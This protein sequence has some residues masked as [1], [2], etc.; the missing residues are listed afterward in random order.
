[1][2]NILDETGITR[3]E[4]EENLGIMLYP[5]TDASLK[6]FIHREDIPG[7]TSVLI[8]MRGHE[9]DS[10]YIIPYLV[11]P[12]YIKDWGVDADTLFN[13]ALK[14][15]PMKYENLQLRSGLHLWITNGS[16]CYDVY[17]ENDFAATTILNIAHSPELIGKYGSFFIVPEQY[18]AIVAPIN[19]G[20]ALDAL[21]QLPSLAKNMYN[22]SYRQI[23]L[24]Q[25]LYWYYEGTFTKVSYKDKERNLQFVPS[26]EL[27]A[28]IL[29]LTGKKLN[30][31]LSEIKKEVPPVELR[32]KQDKKI[33]F[34]PH[35]F[36]E[37]NG[38]RKTIHYKPDSIK[39]G[40][41]VGR[42][43]PGQTLEKG[44]AWE[45]N[46]SL[47]YKGRFECTFVGFRDFTFE[48]GRI[49]ERYTVDIKILDPLLPQK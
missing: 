21:Y 22:D 31:A 32:V 6:K 33:F 13:I 4:L 12:E 2:E 29:K 35:V 45:L 16:I 47:Q 49:F 30:E 36:T 40:G 25:D 1:M 37:I 15:T 5:S 42:V 24:N 44:I 28:I 9:M 26:P 14:N 38:E 27:D 23:R 46:R 10:G 18:S 20:S 19:D 7:I 48:K 34:W 41:W 3:E 39:Q 8:V 11:P 17:N 43:I